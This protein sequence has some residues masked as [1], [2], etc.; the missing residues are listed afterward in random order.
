MQS[1]P[2]KTPKRGLLRRCSAFVLVLVLLLQSLAI[3]TSAV[4]QEIELN[5][6][7]SVSKPGFSTSGI[8]NLN[9]G[10]LTEQLRNEIIASMNENLVKRIEDNEL[11]GPV[12]LIITFSDNSVISAY[13]NSKYAKTMTYEAFKASKTAKDLEASFRKNQN[14][15]LERLL[16]EALVDEVRYTYAHL[17]DAAFV[18]TTYENIDAISKIE[19]VERVMISNTYLP[20]AAVSNPVDVYETGIFNSGSVSYTGKGTLVAILD[21]GCDYTHS[22]FTSYAVQSPAYD[23]AFVEKHLES[24]KAYQFSM[25]EGHMLEAREVYYG[26]LTG[27]KI[28]YG[29]DYADKDPDIMP[30]DNSHGTH[31]AGIIGGKDD[32]I[33]GV[34]IDTQF[35][36]MKVF[37]DYKQGAEDGDVLAGLE[38][39]IILGVD[40]INMSLGS[41]CG[42]T[43]ESAADKQYKNDVYSRV[44]QA[45]ISLIVAAS[46]DYSSAMGGENGNTNKTGNPDSATVGSP[47]TYN[48]SMSVASINGQKDNYM[49]ANGDFPVF[50]HKSNNNA[51]K[52]YD[53]FA[54]MGITPGKTATYEYVTVPGVGLA[55]NYAGI[56]VKGKI[57]LVKRGENTFE[58]KVQYAQ[59][60]GA[61]AVII[62]NNVSGTIYMTIG[63]DAKIPAVSINKDDGDILAAKGSGTI[64][65]TLANEAGPFMSDFS[66]WGPNPDLSLKPDITAHGG[67][68]LSAIV[69]NDYEEMSGTS[70][71]CP[72]MCGITVLIRQYV[73]E[74]FKGLS[75]VEERDLVNQLCMSTATI[76]LDKNGNPYSPRKQ[77]AGIADIR[78]ATTTL[79]YLFRDGHNRTKFE[80]GDDPN[81]TGVY[82]MKVGIKNVSDKALSYRLGDIVMT[83]S[84]STSDPEY[85]AEIAYLLNNTTEYVPTNCTIKD[86]VVTVGAGETAYVTVT[87]RLSDADKAYLNST[88]ENGMFVEGYITFDNTDENGVDLN[89]PFLAFYGDWGEAPIF[90]LDYYEVETEAHNDAIDDDDKIKADYYA[91]TPLGLYYYDYVVPLG[92]YLYKMDESLYSPI[93]AT[94]DKAAISYY[95]DAI[96]GLFACYAGLLRGAKEMRIQVKNVS[97]GEVVWEEIQYN[98]YK[99]HYR[100]GPAPYAAKID[101]PAV[102]TETNEILG[103]NNTKFEVTME[104]KLDWEGGENRSDFYSF[105]FYIDYQA[106]T[107]TSYSFRTKW[108][109]SKKENRYYL[110]VMVYDNHYAMSVRPVVVYDSQELMDDGV[111]YKKAYASLSEYPIPVY[112]ETRNTSTKVTIEITDYLDKIA[113]SSMPNGIALSIDDYALNSSLTYIPFP[114]TEGAEDVEFNAD[115]EGITLDIHETVDLATLLVSKDTAITL[116]P[117]YL[118]TLK[119]E[120][121]EGK[122]VIAMK[123]GFVEAINPGRAIV[124]VTSDS[125]GTRE[126]P[127][128]KKL[129][130][131]VTENVMENNPESGMLVKIDALSYSHLETLYAHNTDIDFSEIGATGN[132][133]YLQ[134]STSLSCYPGESFQLFY[135]LKPWN[136]DPSRYTI[137]FQSSNPNVASV[138]PETGVVEANAKGKARISLSIVVDGKTSLLRASLSLEVKSEFIIENRTLVAYKGKGGDVVIPDD[139]GIIYIGA[140]AFAHYDLDNTKYVP[141]DENGYYDFDLKKTPLG[142]KTITSVTIPE[143]VESIQKY[144]F[145]NSSELTDI[146][147]PESCITIEAYAFQ[148][149]KKL[150]N[151]NFD[152]VK[153]VGTSAFENCVELDCEGLGGA[154]T[155]KLYS[156]ANSAFKNT[157]FTS[158]SLPVLSRIGDN[159]FAD[160]KSLSAVELGPRTRISKGMFKNTP[161]NSLVIYS[162]T[163]GDEAFLDCNRLTSVTFKNNLT[164]LGASVFSGCTELS[165]VVFEGECEQIASKAFHKCTSLSSFTLP[166]GKVSIGESAFLESALKTLT[167]KETTEIDYV[168]VAAFSSTTKI[169][170]DTTASQIY[171]VTGN[172]I[173]TN[174]GKTLVMAVPSN[175]TT[176]FTVPAEVEVIGDGAFSSLSLLYQVKF[177]NGSALKE[178]GAS[179]FADCKY[180]TTV[181]LPD[182]PIKIGEYAFS[183]TSSLKN[184]DFANVTE[185][186]QFAFFES[187]IKNVN[188]TSEGAKIGYGA[189]HMT[190]NLSTVVLGKN[191]S[192]GEFAFR[193][194][195]VTSVDLQGDAEILRGAFY[196]CFYLTA[197]DFAD[198]TGK[199]GDEAFWG[200]IVLT[201][202][203]APNITEIGISSFADC[204]SLVTFSADNL[205][206]IGESAFA[207]LLDN[208]YV[209]PIKNVSFPKV[210]KI[211]D[212]AFFQCSLLESANLPSLKEMGQVAFYNCSALQSIVFSDELEAIQNYTF[213]GCK[214]LTTFDISHVKTFGDAAFVGVSLPANLD[215]SSAEKI[216][217]YAF[218]FDKNLTGKEE[219]ALNS[220]KAP[221][222]KEIDYIAFGYNENLQVFEAPSIVTMST[223]VFA[224]T[225]ILEFEVGANLEKID[226]GVF[227]YCENLSA[228]YFKNEAGEKVYTGELGNIK[229]VDG[230]L[231][232]VEDRGYTLLLYPAAKSGEELTVLDGTIRVE[233]GAAQANKSLMRVVLP[234]T[235][236]YIGDYAFYQCDNLKSVTFKSYH[237]PI[238]EGS[239][240][241]EAITID[242]N[243]IAEFT[244]FDQLYKYDYYFR[245]L[246]KVTH[247]LYHRNFIDVI[248][249]STTEGLIAIL[250]DNCEG[251]NNIIYEA[252]FDFSEETSGVTVGKFA[253]AFIDAV[254]ALPEVADR[255]D[256]QTVENAILA[257][258]ALKA[259]ADE[260]VYVTD[261]LEQRYNKAVSEYYVDIAEDKIAHLF[262]MAM[263]EYS[264]NAVKDARAT[265]LA[266]TES[267]RSAVENADR[268]NA[269]IAELSEVFGTD[270]NFEQNY[271]DNLPEI[272]PPV[273]PE[274]PMQG[275]D[276]DKAGLPGWA[277]ALICVAGALVL[278]GVAVVV[279]VVLKKRKTAV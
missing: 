51:S 93:P 9:Q 89:A 197:F 220:V 84:V 138:D 20:Q 150:E 34:A 182:Q 78:K 14:K 212:G 91:T 6:G 114:G 7:N 94:R 123:S 69:G 224:E 137:K 275:G 33:T 76:A 244:D 32:K 64:E 221:L 44:E 176:T 11:S 107:V 261:E 228:F 218:M 126:L 158:L 110:D 165:S 163:V 166:E 245:I 214:A 191:V 17:M 252:Y 106:P 227:Q 75:D 188:L 196:G 132:I 46:N 175:S 116:E 164:Y 223:S 134:G 28:V 60:A 72:N 82:E 43:Y 229:V 2:K 140:Y 160:C 70:M 149:C 3:S 151:V 65:F 186:G 15:V 247:P 48:A 109:N 213:Y 136:L 259:H 128:Y 62:Y 225:D 103:N 167:F 59:E 67:N 118:R 200:C 71:A 105:S 202:V 18:S 35:A 258:N 230:V 264:F 251:Y 231:Y 26:N 211:G 12:G 209:P 4:A 129:V 95:A 42:Y 239:M 254:K 25:D 55:V 185:I 236:K 125:W 36:I 31:V 162:D 1:T 19:G 210:V 190:E 86:G 276:D 262:D 5:S 139:E 267:Q 79:A 269:K 61:I 10:E 271:E 226:L 100:G 131:N 102:N 168:G 179:A 238:I 155:N 52:P 257:Y 205:E 57:A 24:T 195:N 83:E 113:A 74:N 154:N 87:I 54:M 249:K 147:L 270:I 115:E 279:V 53:F 73:Q 208:D 21:T 88:F 171:K 156:T 47:S 274:P 180:L 50:F 234:S 246:D 183:G 152:Y 181:T 272:E 92:G 169:S 30:L 85:V 243:N 189:F 121:E 120:I 37:S 111:T 66:S 265:Y 242:K 23:R 278:G 201:E 22:A 68:I 39:A 108:D 143:G 13:S 250:P 222:L 41:S 219:S 133:R 97:T 174:D 207:K 81:R 204:Y 198:V 145:Y 173:Y 203:I 153:I 98:C 130:I 40:A 56:D 206:V 80:L 194:S 170:I 277:I 184:F 29:Y 192:I 260:L 193:G 63:N 187:A 255:F 45:G 38:D 199:I 148:N 172:A 99:S 119:W 96:S 144:A 253:V 112:Q 141:K 159:A 90:D 77:G 268:L 142:N 157:G 49:L 241:G 161:V 248:G 263:N 237:A 273:E 232:R 16:D 27:E 146:I 117:D 122:D 58:E 240:L 216:G 235:L 266:L 217:Q 215:L 104:A 101:L 177:A 233:T 135:E 8:A 124:R 127:I 178:I 256:V